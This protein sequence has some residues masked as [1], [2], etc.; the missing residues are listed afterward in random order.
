MARNYVKESEW[1]KNNYV[2]IGVYLEKNEYEE[3]V[4]EIKTTIGLS[5]FL[6]K[7]IKLYKEDKSIF[8]NDDNKA[9]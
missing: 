2:R 4:E 3:V 5:D 9:A 8:I 1:R 7:A 6:K